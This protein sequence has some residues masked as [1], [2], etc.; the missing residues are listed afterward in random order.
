MAACALA[1]TGVRAHFAFVP[2]SGPYAR[3]IHATVQAVLKRPLD[4]EQLLARLTDFYSHSSFIGVGANL[5]RLKDVVACNYARLG[6]FTDGR[7]VAVMSA[8]DNLT[9]GAA[10]GALQL[11]NRMLGFPESSG[12]TAPAV[13][14]A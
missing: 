3:G 7:T 14:W 11:M 4:R 13:G 9:K 12:L 2:H 1:A 10:G 8:A 6:A 5:P